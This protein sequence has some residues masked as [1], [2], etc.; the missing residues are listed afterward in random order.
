MAEQTQETFEQLISA[1]DAANAANDSARLSELAG[2]LERLEP[3]W[4]LFITPPKVDPIPS[5]SSPYS[6]WDGWG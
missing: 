2:A 6:G 1:Y 4:F 3:S 5:G